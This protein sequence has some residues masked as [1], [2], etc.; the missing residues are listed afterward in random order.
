MVNNFIETFIISFCI[1]HTYRS[2]NEIVFN[3]IYTSRAKLKETRNIVYFN[4]NTD[5]KR[6]IVQHEPHNL[7]VSIISFS[8]FQRRMQKEHEMRIYSEMI[9]KI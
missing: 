7:T 6:K 5:E 3:T 4:V 8:S 9:N 2:S 1:H